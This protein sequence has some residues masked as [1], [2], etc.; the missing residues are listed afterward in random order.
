MANGVSELT[1]LD[2]T[3]GGFVDIIQN[4]RLNEANKEY[5]QRENKVF[6]DINA[7]E[8][9]RDASGKTQYEYKTEAHIK[10][11]QEAIDRLNQQIEAEKR[12]NAD[13]DRLARLQQE[14]EEAERLH[15]EQQANYDR[16]RAQENAKA[17]TADQSNQ[18]AYQDA[19]LDKQ[20]AEQRE[21]EIRRQLEEAQK[22]AEDDRRRVEEER[23]KAEEERRKAE[24]SRKDDAPRHADEQNADNRPDDNRRDDSREVGANQPDYRDLNQGNSDQ[25]S[26]YSAQSSYQDNNYQNDRQDS[27]AQNNSNQNIPYQENRQESFNYQDNFYQNDRLE[28]PVQSNDNQNDYHQD[29][30]QDSSVQ[31]N[32]YQNSNDY[33]NSSAQND[34]SENR[35]ESPA[36][37]DT[38]DNGYQNDTVQNNQDNRQEA[39][40]QDAQPYRDVS[41]LNNSNEQAPYQDNRYENSQQNETRTYESRQESQPV[42]RQDEQNPTY[43]QTNENQPAPAPSGQ[44]NANANQSGY[45]G[46]ENTNQGNTQNTN[47]PDANQTDQNKVYGYATAN[48]IEAARQLT[49]SLERQAEEARRQADAVRQAHEQELMKDASVSQ[50]KQAY[51]S[52]VNAE[53]VAKTTYEQAQSQANNAEQNYYRTIE[54]QVNNT[55][56]NDA[57]YQKLQADLRKLEEDAAKG[58]PK[59]YEE[60]IAQTKAAMQA[61]EDNARAQ[62]LASAEAVAAKNAWETQSS[63]A[64]QAQSAYDSARSETYKA[65]NTYNAKIADYADAHDI[66]DLKEAWETSKTTSEQAAKA[67]NDY[68]DN[69]AKTPESIREVDNLRQELNSASAAKNNYSSA[70]EHFEKQERLAESADQF[71]RYEF[72]DRKQY[73]QAVAVLEQKGVKVLATASQMSNDRGES[74]YVLQ[75]DRANSAQVRNVIEERG[76][77]ASAHGHIYKDGS[78]EAKKT[79]DNHGKGRTDKEVAKTEH[80]YQSAL[81]GYG[82]LLLRETGELYH[83]YLMASDI[84]DFIKG[85]QNAAAMQTAS[86]NERNEMSFHMADVDNAKLDAEG[87]NRYRMDVWKSPY[88]ALGLKTGAFDETKMR[89]R[90][91]SDEFVQKLSKET[92]RNM[93]AD[94]GLREI[95]VGYLTRS[96]I[97]KLTTGS[98]DKL[99]AAGLIAVDAKGNIDIAALKKLSP[100]QLQKI[101]ID[102]EI[103]EKVVLK[104]LE[105]IDKWGAF[106]GI[107]AAGASV[108]KGLLKFVGK[109]DDNEGNLTQTV[110]EVRQGVNYVKRPVDEVVKNVKKARQIRQSKRN[111]PNSKDAAKNAVNTSKVDIKE[112]PKL[113]KAK[114]SKIKKAEK[115]VAKTKTNIAR[116]NKLMEKWSNSIFGKTQAKLATMTTNFMTKTVVGK[117]I[118]AVSSAISTFVST[119]LV[120][121]IGIAL[122]GII[123]MAAQITIILI[124]FCLVSSLFEFE[125]SPDESTTYVLYNKVLL[126][127]ENK[128]IADL[129]DVDNLWDKID[130]SDM[131]FGMYYEPWTKYAEHKV[132]LVTQDDGW[133]TDGGLFHY[134]NLKVY[135]NP[136][137]F[138]P[139]YPDDYYIKLSKAGETDPN[140]HQTVGKFG[141]AG[142]MLTFVPNM[143]SFAK[144]G[145][146]G[147]T[148]NIKDII[149]MMDVMFQFEEN[150][151]EDI[152]DV[153]EQTGLDI[154]MEW[155]ETRLTYAYRCIRNIFTPTPYDPSL[156]LEQWSHMKAYCEELFLCTH[157][158]MFDIDVIIFDCNDNT[159][160]I[161]SSTTDFNLEDANYRQSLLNTIIADGCP[162][163]T[164]GGCRQSKFYSC[165][166]GSAGAYTAHVGIL[167][168][169][170][171]GYHTGQFGHVGTLSAETGNDLENVRL[172]DTS[173]RFCLNNLLLNELNSVHTAGITTRL[174]NLL[175]GSSCWYDEIKDV[176]IDGDTEY[177]L[178]YY[179]AGAYDNADVW[180]ISG[181]TEPSGVDARS[182]STPPDITLGGIRTAYKIGDDATYN[183]YIVLAIP[184][185]KDE[186]YKANA[187]A[188]WNDCDC[189][190]ADED[191][192]DDCHC[193]SCHCEDKTYEDLRIRKRVFDLYIWS[194]SHDVTTGKLNHTLPVLDTNFTV[195]FDGDDIS[196]TGL[197]NITTCLGHDCRYCGGHTFIDTK[198]IV[199]GFTDA[200]IVAAGGKVG[201][202]DSS[203]AIIVPVI[204]EDKLGESES[205]AYKKGTYTSPNVLHDGR[206]RTLKAVG[207]FGLNMLP[208]RLS[209]GD[210]SA[211]NPGTPYSWKTQK[212]PEISDT[213][214]TEY[215]YDGSGWEFIHPGGHSYKVNLMLYTA[216]DI[217]DI[218]AAIDYP[219]GFFPVT[220][221]DYEGW[222][223]S[224]MQLAL[225]KYIMSWEDTYDFDIPI[226]LNCLQ[227]SEKQVSEIVEGVKKYCNNTLHSSMTKGEEAAIVAALE[228]VGNGT[229][230]QAHHD[231]GYLLNMDVAN[232]TNMDNTANMLGLTE[233]NGHPCTATDCS[234][235]ASYVITMGGDTRILSGRSGDHYAVWST[236]G[237]LDQI[238]AGNGFHWSGAST[239]LRPGDIFIHGEHGS[240]GI[241]GNH[242][243]VY[244]GTLTEDLTLSWADNTGSYKFSLDS[245]ENYQIDTQIVLKAGMPITVD[246]TRLDSKGNIYLR[247]GGIVHSWMPSS[248][249]ITTPD[250]ITN[251]YRPNYPN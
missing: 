206:K 209:D 34:Y 105:G 237:F 125:L 68:M 108:G 167:A 11:S 117:I 213:V 115:G 156:G 144:Q 224:N 88:E 95:S 54:T 100:A 177:K 200:E 204:D 245:E 194:V 114:E 7:N 76:Y 39:P 173:E 66:K 205:F 91:D 18:K 60:S 172:L 42:Y 46:Q 19:M 78:Y 77:E 251:V 164:D 191:D 140:T 56:N 26:G 159:F 193:S 230:S 247:N 148:S 153:T 225:Q 210:G 122:A 249:Y 231:H 198:G 73:E 168:K 137:N 250:A 45:S 183:Q 160:E 169:E 82:N 4:D 24:E 15:K 186:V 143:S 207:V 226:N 116:R 138:E 151:D 158:E 113:K 71:N 50:S 72:S 154:A 63:V 112:N 85:A 64:S 197:E 127:N 155:L 32:N 41:V 227:L 97:A 44:E 5:N 243:L 23:R 110:N 55:L 187:Y 244:I 150:S 43:Q 165:V 161:D 8:S 166:G 28:S 219:N 182:G 101:G 171:Y 3:I 84:N 129:K 22:R 80:Q 149:C 170:G 99:K 123:A 81:S 70:V 92:G 2:R 178:Y 98:L 59:P 181:E 189:D 30:R 134:N 6:E 184:K 174:S 118:G 176:E 126:K 94:K 199:F 61:A 89:I 52:A 14:K 211:S 69:L 195:D 157:Q 146:G 221:A 145:S 132:H 104:D 128:W 106:A 124:I 192:P 111:I 241:G 40:R 58:N 232:A 139:L 33:Q 175:D 233:K 102:P 37:R 27:P 196:V 201:G 163:A 229:Y 109:F 79:D 214:M 190:D 35:Q 51:E 29:S 21:A 222:T 228:A 87:Q 220:E 142:S 152:E 135:L 62:A 36:Y 236:E 242:A 75:V 83:M 216:A 136:F 133:G 223:E 1:G 10:E 185:V 130:G 208:N 74:V 90:G 47:Q 218:D 240:G 235:F 49:E 131:K 162:G 20:A 212:T 217:F 246:C 67:H 96:D 25:N 141:D 239:E 9:M 12:T 103:F 180:S 38:Q 93:Y 215:R 202:F 107:K 86:I 13:K 57:D 53:S 65:E 234:G 238:D 248:P 31:S 48:E 188:S 121:A 147:H 179:E 17:F 119:I 120:P 16:Y 203:D